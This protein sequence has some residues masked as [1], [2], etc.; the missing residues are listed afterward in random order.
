MMLGN[1]D[2]AIGKLAS[3]SARRKVPLALEV[4]VDGK[5]ITFQINP[6]T[7]RVKPPE[8]GAWS[9]VKDFKD[10]LEFE[11]FMKN[12]SYPVRELQAAA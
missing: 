12:K 3:F 4:T 8:Q 10:W 2:K 6:D 5:P 7:L 1:M 11:K 9:W